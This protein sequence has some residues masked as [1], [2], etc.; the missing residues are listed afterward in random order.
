LSLFGCFDA[1]GQGNPYRR[2]LTI[3]VVVNGV[4]GTFLVDTGASGTILDSAFAD[5]LGLKPSGGV[6][7]E[8][9]YS[10]EQ[11]VTVDVAQ[12][13]IGP[14]L[15]SDAPL[16]VLNLGTLSRMAGVPIVGVLG[17]DLLA[18][19][20]V[21][22]SYSSGTAQVVTEIEDGALPVT[23]T[24]ARGRYFVPVRIGRSTLALLLDSGT[25]MTA[26][27]DSAWQKLPS[28]S[29]GQDRVEGVL[30]SGSS[31]GSALAC[32]P[33]L[34]LGDGT[35]DQLALRELPARVVLPS[36]SGSFADAEF[37]GIVGG[38]IL[39]RWE[40]TLDLHHAFIYLKPDP[41]FRPN[42]YE[43]VT[44]GIQFFKAEDGAFS[45]AAVWK[46]SPAE[47]AG[48]V[49]GD[50]ILSVNGQASA[51]YTLDAFAHQLH[52]APGTHVALEVARPA[53]PE[54]LHMTTRQLVCESAGAH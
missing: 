7:V 19:T 3:P 14:K 8:R 5:R 21:K 33:A 22:L 43:F 24:K 34:A 11:S 37:D 39:A 35:A 53:G 38:D 31:L 15:W 10:T 27:S 18:T 54:I 41:A 4:A 25:N 49:A 45:V 51:T 26:I 23:L 9:A 47:S 52:G 16:A 40:V 48:V 6:S 17:A 32:L 36:Q 50:R 2:L 46:P 42:P 1:H 29:K 13:A 30:S 12:V 44:V 28:A 20:I